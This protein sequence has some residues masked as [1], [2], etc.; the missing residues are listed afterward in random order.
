MA[1]FSSSSPIFLS[2][3]ISLKASLPSRRTLRARQEILKFLRTVAAGERV[4]LH[5]MTGLGFRIVQEITADHAALTAKPRKWMPA[6]R[7]RV[8]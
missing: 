6:A 4:G 2:L 3:A 8:T 5:T 7:F 1:R